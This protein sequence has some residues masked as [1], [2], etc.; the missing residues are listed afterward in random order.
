[1]A[2]LSKMVFSVFLFLFFVQLPAQ[3]ISNVDTIAG[4]LVK[5]IRKD[6]SERVNVET[7]KWYYAAGEDVWL[8]AWVTN[9]ISNKY[10]SR[11][12]N[13]YVDIVDESDAAV[14]QLLLNIPTEHTE[15]Y[16]RLSDSLPEG[17]YWLRAFTSSMLK[18]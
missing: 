12:Q 13:L 18:T 1:M 5:A 14:A 2:Y 7:N 16:I 17:N 9:K 3:N 10:Y 11:S 8:K 4:E 6:K 15:G